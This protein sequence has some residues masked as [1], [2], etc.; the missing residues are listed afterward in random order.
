MKMT[1]EECRDRY[2]FWLG[3]GPGGDVY[4]YFPAGRDPKDGLPLT[5]ARRATEAE[6]SSWLEGDMA[7]MAA[8]VSR[9]APPGFR[10]P[11]STRRWSMRDLWRKTT[12]RLFGGARST[13]P[14]P[15]GP[16]CGLGS[17]C[18]HTSEV[19]VLT[20]EDDPPTR[21]TIYCPVPGCDCRGTW[22]LDAP[23][24]R[25]PIARFRFSPKSSVRSPIR[26][27]IACSVI[28]PPSLTVPNGS[29]M[30]APL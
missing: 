8:L 10:P 7:A 16:R 22:G 26:Q 4:I 29:D 17:G 11:A 24:P 19:H 20:A 23:T 30:V 21:G 1:D 12:R 25:R 9:T 28:V 15:D 14:E 13:E 5:H 3:S 6:Y 18:G 27:R 2:G